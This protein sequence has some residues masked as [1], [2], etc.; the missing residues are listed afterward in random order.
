MESYK[1]KITDR[2]SF[3]FSRICRENE[4]R[5]G[6]IVTVGDSACIALS[7]NF[8]SKFDSG[9]RIS[10]AEENLGD[11]WGNNHSYVVD[12]SHKLYPGFD[13][14]PGWRVRK[15]NNI[16]ATVAEYIKARDYY[17]ELKI[18]VIILSA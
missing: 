1:F 13:H 5:D 14:C 12:N 3:N 17:R 4:G 7:E 18:S 15:I 11:R 16:S 6:F 2:E 8:L 9:D 10:I